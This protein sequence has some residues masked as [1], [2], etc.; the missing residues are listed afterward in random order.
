[1][2]SAAAGNQYAPSIC[3]DGS[4]G[5]IIAWY[6]GRLGAANYDIWAQRVLNDG[7]LAPG[8][9]VRVCG[10]ANQQINPVVL[11]DTAAGCFIA[12]PDLRAKVDQ[13]NYVHPLAASGTHVSNWPTDGIAVCSAP[14][15]QTNPRI[16]S[17]GAGGVLIAWEDL[18]SGTDDDIYAQRIDGA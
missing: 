8:W 11:A 16:A 14:H 17:D 2:I 5:A 10:A 18:R 3:S 13:A 4:G 12:G 15:D 9:P 7:S 6:D 1:V